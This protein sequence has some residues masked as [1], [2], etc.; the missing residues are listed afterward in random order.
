ML[1]LLIIGIFLSQAP[2]SSQEP[3]IVFYHCVSEDDEC[4][5]EEEL[6]EYKGLDCYIDNT[7]PVQACFEKKSK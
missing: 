1:H 7:I 2:K 3:K 4:L 6:D 5:I